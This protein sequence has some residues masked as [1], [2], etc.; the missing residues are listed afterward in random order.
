MA[1]SL[2]DVLS[3]IVDHHNSMKQVGPAKCD[4]SADKQSDGKDNEKK[5]DKS[6][7]SNQRIRDGAASSKKC[8]ICRFDHTATDC[9]MFQE[10]RKQRA[11]KQGEHFAAKS[12]KDD[13]K[14]GAQANRQVKKC[15][16]VCSQ[17]QLRQVPD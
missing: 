14:R 4:A 11:T 13:K 8:Q 12:D 10:L 7:V 5:G 3:K 1:Y 6:A 17:L 16:R 15:C 2:D 9:T